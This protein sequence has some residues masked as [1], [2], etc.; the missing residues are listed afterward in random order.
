MLRICRFIQDEWP[1]LHRLMKCRWNING[2]LSNCNGILLH[3]IQDSDRLNFFLRGCCTLRQLLRVSRTVASSISVAAFLDT[4]LK[5]YDTLSLQ[6]NPRAQ[7]FLD[8][9]RAHVNNKDMLVTFSVICDAGDPWRL[10]VTGL[11][12]AR[13]FPSRYIENMS[14]EG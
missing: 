1:L 2:V 13:S 12:C 6:D 10:H 9:T 11:L 8:T 7:R 3:S 4:R 5:I 14:H